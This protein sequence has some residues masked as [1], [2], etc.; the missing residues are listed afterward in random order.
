MA[1]PDARP[2]RKLL[3]I[4]D[5]TPESK[6]AQRYAAV[7]A[8]NAAARVLLLH[9]IQPSH[10]EHWMA[11]EETIREEARTAAKEL[12][13]AA[14]QE[15]FAV[16][17]IAP[18][19]LVREGAPRDVI[20]DLVAEDREIMVLVLAAADGK[21]GPGP[22]VSSFTSNPDAFRARPIPVMVIPG[23]MTL[24]DVEEIA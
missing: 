13:D 7:R 4:V 10:F 1:A 11:V 24:E 19:H 12:L 18:D 15:V 22:L 16:S 23:C 9:I 14:A 17:R 6:L 5:D 8:K 20:G 3:V 2:R 21:D